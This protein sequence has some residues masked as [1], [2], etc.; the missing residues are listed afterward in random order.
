MTA[1]TAAK[2]DYLSYKELSRLLSREEKSFE[3]FKKKQKDEFAKRERDIEKIKNAL[4]QNL[5]DDKSVPFDEIDVVIETKKRIAAMSEKERK[6]LREESL[7]Y[8]YENEKV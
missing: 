8:Y 5:D 2:L 6:A 7:K 1:Q 4:M 3:R